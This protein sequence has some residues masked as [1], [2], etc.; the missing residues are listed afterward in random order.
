MTG[1]DGR[2]LTKDV[3][4]RTGLRVATIRRYRVR[5]TFSPPDGHTLGHPWWRLETVDA[6][7]ASRKLKS[8]REVEA[9]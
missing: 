8:T 1:E 9:G 7:I 3:A 6:W 5:G 2:L 4:A